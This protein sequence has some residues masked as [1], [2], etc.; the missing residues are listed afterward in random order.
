MKDTFSDKH[1]IDKELSVLE[2]INELDR[3]N[4]SERDFAFSR[5]NAIREIVKFEAGFLFTCDR[6]TYEISKLAIYHPE[7]FSE[8]DEKYILSRISDLSNYKTNYMISEIAIPSSEKSTAIYFKRKRSFG[9]FILIGNKIFAENLYSYAKEIER[10]VNDIALSLEYLFIEKEQ[11]VIY[12]IFETISRE[13]DL[14]KIYKNIEISVKKIFKCEGI[15]IL[16]IREEGDQRKYVRNVY[17]STSKYIGIEIN[18]KDESLSWWCLKNDSFI[19][20]NGETNEDNR[21]VVYTKNS[22]KENIMPVVIDDEWEKSI[23]MAPLKFKEKMIGVLKIYNLNK[24]TRFDEIVDPEMLNKISIPITIA[25]ENAQE[26]SRLNFESEQS[27]AIGKITEAIN[28][29][30]NMPKEVVNTCLEN[31]VKLVGSEMGFIAVRNLKN[32]KLNIDYSFNRE[33]RTIPDYDLD[34]M[35]DKKGIINHVINSGNYYLT[36][37]AQRDPQFLKLFTEINSKIAVPLRPLGEKEVIGVLSVD[38]RQKVQFNKNQAVLL[39]NI[40]NQI[41]SYLY[42]SK[43]LAALRRLA[44][45]FPNY[46]DIQSLFNEALTRLAKMLEVKSASIR[47]IEN[48]VLVIKARTGEFHEGLMNS[49]P[50]GDTLSWRCINN[51]RIEEVYNLQENPNLLY[52]KEYVERDNL[53]SAISVPMR[54]QNEIVGAIHVYTNRQHKFS[55]VEKQIIELMAET[56][57][58]SMSSVE[59]LQRERKKNKEIE[60]LYETITAN[61]RLMSIHEMATSFAH[62]SR[63]SLN[64]IAPL[65]L[66]LKNDV[67]N[68]ISKNKFSEQIQNTFK[69]NLDSIGNEITILNTYFDKLN[70]YARTLETKME[71]NSLNSVLN[72][73]LA[74][75]K[76]RI[77]NL[78]I[79]LK[80]KTTRDFNFVFDQGQIEQVLSN[81]ILNAIQSLELRGISLYISTYS[82][83][84]VIQGYS[85]NCIVIQ[86]SDDGQGIK[87]ENQN[88]IFDAFFTTKGLKN[89]NLRSKGTGFGLTLCKKLVEDDH[90]GL[91]EF[92]SIWGRGATFEIFL[93]YILRSKK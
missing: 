25:L 2:W 86:V 15:S 42:R 18:E 93:P 65:F 24:N 12:N 79:K 90:E 20:F 47:C 9:G 69:L 26:F 85:K 92:N 11:K 84:K 77:D 63:S 54:K 81:I 40:G 35:H 17:D 82:K 31:A 37:D 61:N 30:S 74:L 68:Q 4:Y 66:D 83:E 60:E 19:L 27:N 52:Y 56:L 38:S 44:N 50:R 5:L 41:A 46:N 43:Y 13:L 91:L 72:I 51:N 36:T 39:D 64:R 21:C 73:V 89:K 55:Q 28:S 23:L 8:Q 70:N 7:K 48:N 14:K 58:I 45:P 53:V 33:N 6:H 87:N 88:K 57:I 76:P 32:N 59:A 34:L 49:I 78:N 67:D 29:P 10:I 62:D 16:V 80:K 75:M 1:S 3:F 71:M 22:Q